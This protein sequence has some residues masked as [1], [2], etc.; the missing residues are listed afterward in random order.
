MT[1]LSG[2]EAEEAVAGFFWPG[3]FA[4]RLQIEFGEGVG[5]GDAEE[6]GLE[7]LGGGLEQ[8]DSAFAGGGAAADQDGIGRSDRPG[9]LEGVAGRIFFLGGVE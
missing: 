9:F 4:G 8:D 1:T 5:G 2:K 3:L 6:P 7:C